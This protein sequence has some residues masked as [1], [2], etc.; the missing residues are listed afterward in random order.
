MS[1]RID[2]VVAVDLAGYSSCMN[3]TLR[4]VEAGDLL[5]K[6]VSEVGHDRVVD[7]DDVVVGEAEETATAQ[8]S[9]IKEVDVVP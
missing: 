5:A 6:P 2:R 1:S 9:R 8:P 7:D 4:P 3:C